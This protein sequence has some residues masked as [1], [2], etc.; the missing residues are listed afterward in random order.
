MVERSRRVPPEDAYEACVVPWEVDAG[1]HG[2]AYRRPGGF[3]ETHCV[4]SEE[5]AA[6]VA[7]GINAKAARRKFADIKT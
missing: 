4:G 6:A 2:V 1:L 5:D 3:H 7:R